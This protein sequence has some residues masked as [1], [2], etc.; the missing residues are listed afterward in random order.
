VLRHQLG[1]DFVLLPDLLF[2][3]LNALLVLI[4]LRPLAF[5]RQG[6]IAEQLLLPTVEQ[7]WRHTLVC[8]NLADWDLLDQMQAQQFGLLLCAPVRYSFFKRLAPFASSA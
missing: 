4:A 1:Q 6:G 2:Q 5:Q 3:F 7:A 8:A